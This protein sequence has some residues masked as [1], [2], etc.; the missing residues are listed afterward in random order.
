[1]MRELHLGSDYIS[2]YAEEAGTVLA[3]DKAEFGLSV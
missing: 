2:S 3:W 1:M